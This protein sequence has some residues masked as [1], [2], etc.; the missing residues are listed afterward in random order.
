MGLRPAPV[1][2]GQQ[3]VDDPLRLELVG[4]PGP[5]GVPGAHGAVEGHQTRCAVTSEVAGPQLALGVRLMTAA[6]IDRHVVHARSGN[7]LR[8]GWTRKRY[9]AAMIPGT[10]K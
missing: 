9:G 7:A 10:D 4:H 1:D 2:A 5:G 8:K 3:A 6:L